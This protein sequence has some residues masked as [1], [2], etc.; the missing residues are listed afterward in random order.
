MCFQLQAEVQR[1]QVLKME[2][3]QSVIEAIRVEI[4]LLWEKCF[5]SPEQQEAFAPYHNG[6]SL[7]FNNSPFYAKYIKCQS[8]TDHLR[9]CPPPPDDFTEELLNLH[10][11]EVSTLKKYYE[12]HKDLFE[13]VTKWQDNWTLYLELDVSV[14]PVGF[15]WNF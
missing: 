10:E 6:K 2:S 13:G 8:R 15:G 1:L 12:D 14:V 5:Y 7:L 4:V 9:V 11:A 3:M